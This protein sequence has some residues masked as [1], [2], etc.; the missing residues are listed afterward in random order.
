MTS[1]ILR[2][3]FKPIDSLFT[4]TKETE[5]V[6]TIVSGLPR[7]GTSMMMQI[8]EAGGLTP[9]TDNVRLADTSNAKGYYEHEAVKALS[10]GDYRCLLNAEGCAIKIISSLLMFLPSD[11][12]YKIIFM[13]RDI[14]QILKSQTAML[15]TLN[16]EADSSSD[17]KMELLYQ[18]HLHKVSKW[19]ESQNNIDVL[20]IDY[21][22]V[23]SDPE[24]YILKIEKFLPYQ[25]DRTLMEL[26]IDRSMSHLSKS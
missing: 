5:D 9:V 24:Q 26:T 23:S 22:E 7:S 3:F 15:H 2:S 20:E 18:Q 6:T 16:K 10:K 8:L 11:R 25:L 1:N 17:H 4:K 12:Q 13:R 19:I 21:N 14:D